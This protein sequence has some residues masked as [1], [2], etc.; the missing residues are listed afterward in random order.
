MDGRLRGWSFIAPSL[1][2]G[3]EFLVAVVGV[4]DVLGVQARPFASA[5]LEILNSQSL[6]LVF[7]VAIGGA[8][9]LQVLCGHRSSP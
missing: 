7:H 2:R 9:V 4:G 8:P 5:G 1:E 3:E 6:L